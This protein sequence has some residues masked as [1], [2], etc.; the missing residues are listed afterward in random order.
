M[1]ITDLLVVGVVG[2]DRELGEGLDR[3]LGDDWTTRRIS[4][5]FELSRLERLD[6]GLEREAR[7]E[8]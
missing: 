1:G 2:R 7:G 3:C 6:L 5:L 8:W 4:L